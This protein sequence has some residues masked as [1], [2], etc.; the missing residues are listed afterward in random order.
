[1][2]ISEVKIIDLPKILDDRGNLSFIEGN[3]I[4]N[5]S[6][7]CFAGIV[8]IAHKEYKVLDI[9]YFKSIINGTPDIV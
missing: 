4:G 9:D 2:K 8:T 7:N 3:N 5:S 6:N 1:M